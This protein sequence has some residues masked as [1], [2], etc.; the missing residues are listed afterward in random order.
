[1]LMEEME[2]EEKEKGKVVTFNVMVLYS[3]VQGLDNFIKQSFSEALDLP[4]QEAEK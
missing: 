4:K 2:E 3:S 1:M